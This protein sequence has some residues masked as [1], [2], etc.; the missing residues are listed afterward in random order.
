MIQ[1][2]YFDVNQIRSIEKKKKKKLKECLD[3]GV[4]MS[5][6]EVGMVKMS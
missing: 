6:G 1:E 4:A 5:I 3:G 2:L